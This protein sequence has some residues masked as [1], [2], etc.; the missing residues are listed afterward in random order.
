[1]EFRTPAGVLFHIPN[2]WWTCADMDK[3]SIDG[4]QCYPCFPGRQKVQIVGL[5]EIEPH[6]QKCKC[7]RLQKI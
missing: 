5:A 6:Y 3:F 1:M 2:E 7:S 4:S